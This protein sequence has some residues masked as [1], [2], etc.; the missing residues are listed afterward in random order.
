MGGS[1]FIPD[2]ANDKLIACSKCSQ[3]HDDQFYPDDV[4]VSA[5][6]IHI[7]QF[8]AG[9][10]PPRPCLILYAKRTAGM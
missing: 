9:R 5:G 6:H 10:S 3:F 1:E 8:D 4:K 7:D 2:F